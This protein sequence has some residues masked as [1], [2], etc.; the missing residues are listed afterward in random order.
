MSYLL[1]PLKI[2]S[3]YIVISAVACHG[4][5]NQDKKDNVDL[6]QEVTRPR[7]QDSVFLN[8]E[9]NW[10]KFVNAAPELNNPVVREGEG[11]QWQPL[12]ITDWVFF[13]G[14]RR[15]CRTDRSELAGS[16]RPGAHR[17]KTFTL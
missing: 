6:G 7:P 2:L 11:M 13:P 14:S 17:S 9:K 1:N 15:S 4:K 16:R 10:K 3:L 5:T 12:I 8:F